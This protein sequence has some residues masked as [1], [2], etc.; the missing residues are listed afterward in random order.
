MVHMF[1]AIAILSSPG[2]LEE[3]PK[4]TL[5]CSVNFKPLISS[6]FVF[7]QLWR[8]CNKPHISQLISLLLKHHRWAL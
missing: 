8:D 5:S 6:S 2:M 1:I 3:E 4:D 7:I